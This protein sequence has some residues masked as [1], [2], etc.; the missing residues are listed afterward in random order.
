M[1]T[2]TTE[3]QPQAFWDKIAKKY[4]AQPV[5]DPN[6]YAEKLA[7]VAGYLHAE[8]RVLEIGCGTG[9]TA[10]HLAPQVAQITASDISHAM[11]EIAEAKRIDADI[12]NLRVLQAEAT[13]IL[14][15]APFDA[16]TAFSLL[17]LVPDLT[18]VLAAV[19]AQLKPGGL[20]LSKTVCLGD[21]NPALRLFVRG[22][23]VLGLAPPVTPLRKADLSR[24]LTR[25][26]FELLE[27][28]YFGKGRRN[29]F[30]VARRLA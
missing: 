22:L 30:L 15:E 27:T 20:F 17:H 1:H 8:D 18:A 10:L 11:I 9:S 4:A 2:A 13:E 5:A 7:C 6:A 25:A 26:G 16:I 24:A 3:P 21:A 19:H 28:R 29:P 23:G 12:A 14:P